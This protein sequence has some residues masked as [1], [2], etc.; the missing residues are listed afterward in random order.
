MPAAFL[1]GFNP[2]ISVLDI[3][4]IF[5]T[6]RALSQ[7]LREGPFG[8]A[9]L[10]SFASRGV[11]ALT[12]LAERPQ[13]PDLEQAAREPRCLQGAEIPRDGFEDPDRPVRRRRRDRDRDQFQRALYL[14]ADRPDRRA[15]KSDRHHH[16]HEIPRGAEAH[17]GDRARR[18]GGHRAVQQRVLEQ[19]QRRAARHRQQGVRRDA[20]AGRGD[21]G[22]GAERPRSRRSRPRSSACA[23]PTRPSARRCATRWRRRRAPLTRSAPARR[24]RRCSRSTTRSARSSASRACLRTCTD[25]SAARHRGHRPRCHHAGDVVCL[26]VQCRGARARALLCAAARLD[27]GAVPLRPGLDDLPRPRARRWKAAGTS[28]CAWC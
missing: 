19:A 22:S 3:P 24:A 11:H 9:L 28:P 4:Y 25:E 20:P 2:V 1:G 17:G 26:H 14:A 8:K 13:E 21:E 6:D 10:A 27:R 7:K 15:G 18:D 16:H 12:H 5:P 23:S